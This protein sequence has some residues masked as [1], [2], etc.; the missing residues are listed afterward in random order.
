MSAVIAGQVPN[1]PKI[2]SVKIKHIFYALITGKYSNGTKVNTLKELTRTDCYN[3][4]SI[5]ELTQN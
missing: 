5:I 4:L 1:E 2:K 3:Y